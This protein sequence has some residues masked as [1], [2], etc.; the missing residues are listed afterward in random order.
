MKS[1]PQK[2]SEKR[3]LPTRHGRCYQR[4]TST[5]RD[6]CVLQ[7]RCSLESERIGPLQTV[8]GAGWHPG[9]GKD[10]LC[11]VGTRPPPAL[12]ARRTWPDPDFQG[13]GQ[14]QSQHVLLT[15]ATRGS[16]FH[17]D[18]F[19]MERDVF[20]HIEDSG[21]QRSAVLSEGTRPVHPEESCLLFE[22]L[23]FFPTKS[24]KHDLD[25]SAEMVGHQPEVPRRPEASG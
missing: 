4:N 7:P 10:T 17:H 16:C 5:P 9:G 3:G 23:L 6:V 12:A 22:S 2:E 15:K 19:V 11:H 20:R 25:I 18:C 1:L 21:T 8:P 13:C 14:E 24:P